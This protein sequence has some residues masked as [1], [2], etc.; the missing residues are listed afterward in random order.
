MTAVHQRP[1]LLT[2]AG[3][4]LGCTLLAALA[5]AL[6]PHGGFGCA[7]HASLEGPLLRAWAHWDARWYVA[8]A[9]EGYWYVPGEQSP[10]AFF[11]LYPLLLRGGGALGL[12]APSAGVLVT[13]ACGVAGLLAFRRWAAVLAGPGAAQGALVLLA[14]YPFAFYL[15]GAVYSDALY[16][17]LAV[18][19]FLCLERGQ[20]WPAALLGALATACRPVA[21]AVVA[22]LLVRQ[23][24][25]RR[26]RGERLRPSDGV[27]ALAGAGL[28]AWMLF[29]WARF[30]D[31][32]AF[33]HVQVAWQ[34][35]SGWDTLTK[36]FVRDQLLHRFKW[37]LLL[38][39]LLHAGVA[40][41][42]LAL[43]PTTRRRLGAGYAAYLA[44]CIGLPV[45]STKDFMGLGRY[46]LAAFPAFLTL[47][48]LLAERPRLRRA[49][50]WV[51]G[52]G[53][54]WA[55]AAFASGAYVS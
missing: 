16:L 1:A 21:P 26:A 31:P 42:L 53:L 51:S 13:A 25:L 34:Q 30:D 5:A 35:G 18:G 22:G 40:F 32:L 47:A 44:L 38:R 12:D 41:G 54:A 33:A 7:P 10:V 11:P 15:Y 46:A 50:P 29:L 4:L 43:V 23:W 8:I 19:A 37:R 14:L 27:P 49:W 24:E 28:A 3:A 20:V 39:T 45:L 9:R 52:A 48:L 6:A 2:V 55:T 17:L 36:A